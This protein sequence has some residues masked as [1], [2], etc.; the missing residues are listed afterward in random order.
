MTF[1]DEMNR[2]EAGSNKGVTATKIGKIK[3]KI[4]CCCHRCDFNVYYVS[5]KNENDLPQA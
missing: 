5:E 1:H 2:L 4:I 3:L